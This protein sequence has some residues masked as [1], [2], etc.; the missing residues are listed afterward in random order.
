VQLKPFSE[1]GVGGLSAEQKS[2]LSSQKES[3]K[4]IRD[5][6]TALGKDYIGTEWLR[7]KDKRPIEDLIGGGSDNKL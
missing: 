7:K 2:R 5:A 4:V 3:L 1:G 6:Y